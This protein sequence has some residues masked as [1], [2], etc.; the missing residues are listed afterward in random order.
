MARRLIKEEGLLVGGSAGTNMFAAL[1]EC[2][3]LKKGQN[4]VV[5]LPDG[6]RNYMYVLYYFTVILIIMKSFYFIE[7][8]H[9]N[10]FFDIL[11]TSQIKN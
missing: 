10:I 8:I 6:I 5:I 3:K 9:K 7:L 2:K 4:C 1:Q 11:M